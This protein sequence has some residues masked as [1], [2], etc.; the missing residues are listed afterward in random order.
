MVKTIEENFGTKLVVLH[1]EGMNKVINVISDSS[2]TITDALTDFL[3]DYAG[4]NRVFA[5]IVAR[6]FVT[7]VL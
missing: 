5:E 6:A 3:C 4:F 2:T 1:W 7:V